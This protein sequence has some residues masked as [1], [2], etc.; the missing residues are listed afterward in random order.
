MEFLEFILLVVILIVGFGGVCYLVM[1]HYRCTL[2][3]A[4]KKV[5]DFFV[6]TKKPPLALYENFD[7]YCEVWDII[8]TTISKKYYDDMDRILKTS[9]NISFYSYGYNSGLPYIAYSFYC[10]EE[11]KIILE[12]LIGN[13]VKKYLAIYGCDTDILVDWKERF[14]LKMPILMVRYATNNEESNMIKNCLAFERNKI[15][16][17][18]SPLIDDT[19]SEDLT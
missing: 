5:I 17:K 4:I 2:V 9:S 14:D 1:L 10:D 18:H 6:G 7:L 3:E 15:V 12:N 11:A 8:K 16:K 19:E 13:I